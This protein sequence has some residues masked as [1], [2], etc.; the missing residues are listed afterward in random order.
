MVI[1]KIEVLLIF[2]LNKLMVSC[3]V[4]YYMNY[5]KILEIELLQHF[6]GLVFKIFNNLVSELEAIACLLSYF[7]F[8]DQIFRLCYKFSLFDYLKCRN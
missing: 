2:K 6:I 5:S 1:T 4:I 7:W 3:I 8:C